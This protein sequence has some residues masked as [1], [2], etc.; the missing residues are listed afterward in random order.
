MSFRQEICQA[1]VRLAQ[2]IYY[3]SVGTVEFL[4]ILKSDQFYFIEVN[5]RIQV[6][7]TV[8]EVGYRSGTD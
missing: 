2:H 1:V 6:E 5:P 4:V 3:D 7:Y 8:S